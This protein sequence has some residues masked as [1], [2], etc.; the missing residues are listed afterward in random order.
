MI[1]LPTFPRDNQYVHP[2][3]VDELRTHVVDMPSGAR[4]SSRVRADALGRSAFHRHL[5]CHMAARMFRK[6]RVED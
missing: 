3:P 2:V 4:R 5:R 1:N 6:V